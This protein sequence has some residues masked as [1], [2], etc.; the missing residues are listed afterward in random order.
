MKLKPDSLKRSTNP[1]PDSSRK[2]EKGL[3]SIKLERNRS[4]NGHF[5]NTKDRSSHCGSVV[6]E[7]N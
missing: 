2:K 1:L 4:Y 7:S 6:N 3:K 5:R